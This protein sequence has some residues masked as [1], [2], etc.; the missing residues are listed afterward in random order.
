MILEVACNYDVLYEVFSHLLCGKASFGIQKQKWQNL[1]PTTFFFTQKSHDTQLYNLFVKFDL[2]PFACTRK[3][4]FSWDAK[5]KSMI[6]ID[7]DFFFTQKSCD[8]QLYN[9][10][11]K[12]DLTPFACTRKSFFIWDAK[13]KSM[14]SIDI[15]FFFTQKLCDT[16]LY[17]LLHNWTLNSPT[18]PPSFRLPMGQ[19]IS[20]YLVTNYNH[21]LMVN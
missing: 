6:S 8:T 14:I 18:L 5:S 12:F 16:Q 21:Q 4:F 1:F 7:I 10:F 13:S 3:S 19:N 15:D 2:T 20:L 9:L 11:V 17:N